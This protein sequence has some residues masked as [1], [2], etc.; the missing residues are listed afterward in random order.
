MKL[1][2]LKNKWA[3]IIILLTTCAFSN[4]GQV[5]T[6]EIKV[7]QDVYASQKE[8]STIL[9]GI[10][11]LG[12][13]IDE[14]NGDSRE[15]YFMFD[16][17][18]IYGKGGL[19]RVAL[20]I[21]ADQKG[22]GGWQRVPDFFINVFG[23]VNP[24][25]ES[26]LTWEN[27]PKSEEVILAEANINSPA[28]AGRYE[29]TGIEADTTLMLKYIISAMEKHLQYVSFVIKG[30]DET[31]G[32]RIWVSSMAWEPAKL[33][34]VQDFMLVEPGA[35]ENFITKITVKGDNSSNVIT[36]DNGTLQMSTDI[37]PVDADNQQ[38]KWS[39]TNGTGKAK[40]STT[41]LLSA[42]KDGTVT[43]TAAAIDGSYIT[44]NAVITISGQDYSYDE[45]NY[46]I[47]GNF[48]QDGDLAKPWAGSALVV[49]SIA[50]I[51]PPQVYANPWDYSFDQI[52]HVPYADKDLSYIFT[53]KAWADEARTFTVDFEDNPANNYTRYGTSSDSQSNGSSDWTFEVTTT[54]TVFKLH[55]I[56]AGML[57]NTTQNMKFMLGKADSKVYVDSV[58]LMTEA[59]FALKAPKILANSF[60][61]YPNPVNA[62][63]ELTVGLT[64]AN[65]KVSIYNAL[66]QKMMEKIATGN[67][68]RFNVSGLTKG[69]YIVKLNDGSCQ[70]FLK[71]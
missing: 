6:T 47:D 20:S 1:N 12:V 33:I 30:K 45:R 26:T 35:T 44:G 57:E 65:A 23:C 68:A 49:G 22:D 50:E 28:G 62:T 52:V 37:L 17:T 42:V 15:T 7:I 69:V 34:V 9:D 24:W 38:I 32:S 16:L 48:A 55:V 39:L 5:A 4:Y 56:F 8:P 31:A 58:A 59:D 41:G 40:I 71:Q 11:D 25:D 63:S 3:L 64:N 36:N 19:V 60:K 70:K 43:V 67:I 54:P 51:D 14:T 21:M 61:V 53:F 13:A 29:L 10:T 18:E 2:L 46:V 66:G 27:K